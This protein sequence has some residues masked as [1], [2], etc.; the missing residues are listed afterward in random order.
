[1]L[2]KRTV[3]LRKLGEDRKTEVKF[4]RFLSNE[5]VTVKELIE[6]ETNKTGNL[7]ANHHVLALQDT[8]ELNYHAHSRRTSGLGPTGDSD[9]MG[10]FLHPLLILE[11]E[12][13]A[14]LGLGDVHAWIRK[15][16]EVLCDLSGDASKK[17]KTSYDYQKMPI[18]EKESYRWLEVATRGKK[19][20]KNAKIITIIADRESDIYEEWYRIPDKK[21]HLL[22]RSCYNRRLANGAL[23][24]D[25][26]AKLDVSG[27]SE[28]EVK[29]REGKRSAHK[30]K[31]EI[32]FGEV[33]I[34]RPHVCSDKNAPEQVKLTVLDVKEMQESVCGNEEPIHWCLLTT[35]TINSFEDALTI[36]GWYCQRWNIEQLFR[37]LKKQ[38]FQ[39]ESSQIET[40]QSLVKLAVITLRAAVQTM[41]LTL[42]RD[43]NKVDRLADDV[44]TKEEITVLTAIQ[45]RLEGKTQKQKNPHPLKTLPWAA[46]II[47]RMGGWKGYAS[48][49]PPGPITMF[50]G[51]IEFASICRGWFLAKDV[52]IP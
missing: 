28:I 19:A 13:G 11:A 17:K 31:L 32:R 33:E 29:A 5:K 24:F 41:Q 12:T 36:T 4:G 48:E 1:M 39:I 27:V 52:C 45:P 51:Q 16:K 47:A 2:Q 15:E 9:Q 21:T 46:W 10:L 3:S 8:T 50:R 35:H 26:V 43:G 20:L 37:T 34:R 30:A 38:G 18:E 22:T 42:A 23:L 49:K 6:I 7:V 44:F 40:G 25:H 14:C